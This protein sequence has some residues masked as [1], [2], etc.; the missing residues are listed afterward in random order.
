MKRLFVHLYLALLAATLGSVI[1]VGVVFRLLDEPAHPSPEKLQAKAMAAVDQLR[2]VPE[3]AF[4]ERL[5]RLGDQLALD[6]V[7][8][9][10]MGE[11]I[12]NASHGPMRSSRA[13][14]RAWE[15]T[16]GPVE[17]VIP[18]RYNRLL[19]VRARHL[20]RPHLP[21][22]GGLLILALVM[23][24]GSYP[25]ARRLT[26]RLETVA[27]GVARWGAG[28]LGYRVHVQ[29]SDEVATL[30]ATFNR[31]AEQVD[32][33]VA[34]QAQLLA[35]ASHELRSPLARLRMALELVGEEDCQRRDELVENA[36]RDIVELDALIEDL[37]LMSRTDGRTPRRPFEKLD[38]GQL[39]A[40]ESAR[41]NV[42]AKAPQVFL[43]GDP[44]LLRHLLRNL[45]ENAER[46]AS[47]K[48]VQAAI[49]LNS[50]RATVVV[51]DR[52][53]GIPEGERERIFAPFYRLPGADSGGAGVGLAL[54][55]QVAHYH[56]GVARVLAREGGGSRFEVSLPLLGPGA[57]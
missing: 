25:V 10:E 20:P 13:G 23:A 36:R 34:Q 22:V 15:H 6:L 26:Q 18:L 17:L 30:A 44:S 3:R 41:A 57:D 38:L 56:G 47:G 48:E 33:L 52:G 27:N 14:W 19:G 55:R 11:V 24:L 2:R 7:I 39:L 32:S 1:A 29:G 4:G 37:L 31:A 16:G 42:P 49:E 5:A 50:Q 54:V 35:N 21:L 8:W 45:L 12:A 46:H 53:P 9:N 43:P 51:E 28:D 40:E